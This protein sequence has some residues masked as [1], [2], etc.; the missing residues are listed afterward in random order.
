MART[1][2]VRLINRTTVPLDCMF[3]G[4]PDVVPPGYKVEKRAKTDKDGE[5][6]VKAGQPVMEDVI[7]GTG[8]NGEP[9]DYVVEYHAAEAYV[10]QHP[11]MGSADPNSIDAADTEYLLGVEG[12]GHD[13]SHVEQSNALEL[14]DTSLLGE[15]RQK[16]R[17]VVKIAGS[18]RESKA[19]ITGRKI[20]ANK[21]RAAMG[22]ALV[23]P[24]G[25]DLR[26]F[27]GR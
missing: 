6:I 20:A 17:T 18:R 1:R 16:G 12:W 4:F 26:Q 8:P 24:Y 2:F 3:D 10:R 27:S 21:R 13:I 15:E 7:V 23:N 14:I 22:E 5:P 11:I 9:G 19:N 25:M